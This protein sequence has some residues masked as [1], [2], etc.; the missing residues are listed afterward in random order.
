MPKNKLN[1][2][3][4]N[5]KVIIILVITIILIITL[6]LVNQNKNK[7]LTSAI[8]KVNNKEITEDTINNYL[9]ASFNTPDNFN[10]NSLPKAQLETIILQYALEQKLLKIVKKD[11][12]ADRAEIKQ[13]IKEAKNKILKEAYLDKLAKEATTRSALEK[14]YNSLSAKL[15]KELEG[16]Q[17]YQAKHILTKNQEEA[18]QIYKQLKNNQDS[19]ENLAKEKSIDHIT[20]KNGGNLGYFI[21]GSMVSEFEEQVKNI[22]LNKLS[23]PFKSKFGWHIIMVTDKRPAQVPELDDIYEQLKKE[24]SYRSI[25]N[26]LN[27]LKSTIKIELLKQDSESKS[28]ASTEVEVINEETSN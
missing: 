9:R 3:K 19:F 24:V 13:K 5:N 4:I 17:E 27:D 16:K 23:S 8:A 25:N 2:G 28:E 11:E 26:Y 10:L 15:S 22:E 21:E 18:N 1:T 12:I 6:L 7:S 14:E 20:A